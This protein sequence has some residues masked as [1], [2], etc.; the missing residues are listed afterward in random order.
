[1]PKSEKPF[2][3]HDIPD[4]LLPFVW[5]GSLMPPRPLQAT[6][7]F[8][9][10]LQH[11]APWSRRLDTKKKLSLIHTNLAQLRQRLRFFPQRSGLRPLWV[12]RPRIVIVMCIWRVVSASTLVNPKDKIDTNIE[13]CLMMTMP[14]TTKNQAICQAWDMLMISVRTA[15]VALMATYDSF[16]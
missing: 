4:I 13:I 11:H 9:L 15:S 12:S 6:S 14:N 2:P 3:S 16:V 5:C 7:V 8:L 1:M 10:N